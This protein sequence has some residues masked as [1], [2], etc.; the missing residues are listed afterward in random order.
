MIISYLLPNGQQ[1]YGVP[2]Q[3]FM[4]G[5]GYIYATYQFGTPTQQCAVVHYQTGIIIALITD[6][7]RGYPQQRAQAACL[8]LTI[9]I[10]QQIKRAK[11]INTLP[12]PER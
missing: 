4:P 10:A 12:R 8:D 1:A 9:D 11:V 5:E 7:H 3:I 6:Q 2:V